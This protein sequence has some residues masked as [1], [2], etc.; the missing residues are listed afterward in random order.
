MVLICRVGRSKSWLWRALYKNSAIFIFDEA[1]A[2]LDAGSREIFYK[3]FN[4]VLKEKTV[5]F[6]TYDN[7]SLK[8]SDKIIRVGD[9]DCEVKYFSC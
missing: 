6:I 8:Y 2:N 9:G 1:E 5:I 3:L 7:S 4:S